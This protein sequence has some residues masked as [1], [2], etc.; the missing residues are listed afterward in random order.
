[1]RDLPRRRGTALCVAGCDVDDGSAKEIGTRSLEPVLVRPRE[2][3]ASRK[4]IPNAESLGTRHDGALHRPDVGDE[5]V[6][7]EMRREG[8]ELREIGGGWGGKGWQVRDARGGDGVPPG[9]GPGVRWGQGF[10]AGRLGRYPP[11]EI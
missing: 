10:G 4:P 5:G 3:M 7:L 9:A 6:G 1:M 2:R 8:V 11:P